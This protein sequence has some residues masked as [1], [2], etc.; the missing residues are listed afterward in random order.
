MCHCNHFEVSSDLTEDGIVKQTCKDC[1]KSVD[2]P[3]TMYA[4][5]QYMEKKKV[6]K[7]RVEYI[8][9]HFSKVM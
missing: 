6:Y 3:G 1:G 9:T 5:I 4:V 2:M 7:G 8:R